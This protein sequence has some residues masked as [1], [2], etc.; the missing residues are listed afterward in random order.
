MEGDAGDGLA[1]LSRDPRGS[2][3]LV[4]FPSRVETRV[5]LAAVARTLV[6]DVAKRCVLCPARFSGRISRSD[7]DL[8]PRKKGRF[9]Y[10]SRQ[11]QP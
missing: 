1:K 11:I 10:P 7:G 5:T 8:S 2:A 4:G 9:I 3:S 6:R